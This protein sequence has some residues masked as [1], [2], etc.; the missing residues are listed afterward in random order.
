MAHATRRIELL[1][2]RC[3][4][5][6]SEAA[7]AWTSQLP[8]LIS[9]P[10]CVTAYSATCHVETPGITSDPGWSGD[11]RNRELP[12]PRVGLCMIRILEA[13]RPESL[14]ALAHCLESHFLT[15]R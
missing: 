3:E 6:G 15:S 14:F 7:D 8:F 4:Q 1:G 9:G 12:H 2:G 13:W 10:R 5:F 11:E